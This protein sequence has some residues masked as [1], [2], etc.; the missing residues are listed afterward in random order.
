[1][2]LTQEAV[3]ALSMLFAGEAPSPDK[4]AEA[5]VASKKPVAWRPPTLQKEYGQ[6]HKNWKKFLD[7]IGSGKDYSKKVYTFLA[8]T[9]ARN[10]GADLLEELIDYFQDLHERKNS[11]GTPQYAPTTFR[12][13]FSVFKQFW[14][15]TNKD[16]LDKQ[17]PIF[18]V[19][20]NNWEKGYAPT[21]AKTLTKDQ[22]RTY[23]Q[24]APNDSH[25]LVI[26]A[27]IPVAVS[28]AA[29]GIEAM[30][31]EW[32]DLKYLKE[33]KIFHL[34]FER[35]KARSIR[36]ESE[37]HC[38]ITRSL[39]VAAILLYMDCF[40]EEKK[41]GRF[42]KYLCDTD[43]TPIGTL[44]Q[45]GKNSVAQFGKTIASFLKLPDHEKYTGHWPRRS[46]CCALAEAGRTVQ[47]IKCLTGHR[48]DKVLQ[49]YVDNT[50]TMKKGNADALAVVAPMPQ[51]VA[52]PAPSA[53]P[54][55]PPSV[56]G[57]RPSA[58]VEPADQVR[59]SEGTLFNRKD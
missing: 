24:T 48:S 51:A 44:R 34:E 37:N 23:L 40:P 27:Y 25:H 42:F 6:N 54:S 32:D 33:E 7:S 18:N 50:T 57:K 2:S 43:T 35:R 39:E 17:A 29:R 26:K 3:D 20:F 19:Y 12:P 10:N 36:Q 31:I 52:A 5:A 49:E 4:P 13:L 15:F 56:L 28:F 1:M 22:L 41:T 58:A 47:Q 38:L 59:A 45:I 30:M 16:E 8:W 9:E 14:L 11:D 21:K 46:A 55:A 53:P